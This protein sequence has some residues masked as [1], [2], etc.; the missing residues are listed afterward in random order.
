M[1]LE[2]LYNFDKDFHMEKKQNTLGKPSESKF[3]LLSYFFH[4][5]REDKTHT[6]AHKKLWHFVCF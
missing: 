4:I 2:T 3:S 6:V 1:H 5:L